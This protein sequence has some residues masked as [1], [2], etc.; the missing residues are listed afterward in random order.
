MLKTIKTTKQLRLDEL[1]KY[2]IDN[3]IE[4]T[5]FSIGENKLMPKDFAVISN[6]SYKSFRVSG[7][8]NFKI[9]GYINKDD[10]FP[11]EVE[12]EITES[13][14]F[15]TLVSVYPPIGYSNDNFVDV[16]TNQTINGVISDDKMI[17]VETERIYALI[18]GKL[19]LIYERGIY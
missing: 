9:T 7:S 16:Y 6:P 14:E 12:E 10:L 8:G 1:I 19:E 17:G 18:E 15:D 3:H 5:T 4:D 13:T 11:V 2:C